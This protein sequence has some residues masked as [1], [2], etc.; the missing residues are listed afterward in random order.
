MVTIEK[1]LILIVDDTPQNIQVLGNI[2]YEKGYNI[3]IST[4]G[5]HALQSVN[6][7]TPDLILLDIQ[8]PEMN[9]FEV[10][11]LLKLDEK[12]KDIP[13]IFLTAIS[14][15]ENIVRGFE[16]GAVDY[17]TKP[18]NT[19]ELIS[20]VGT[21]IELK[22]SREK[23]VELNATKDKFFSIIAH[24]LKNPAFAL[25]F[26]LQ[27]IILQFPG[28]SKEELLESLI[29]L[30][31]ASINLYN[32]LENL[33]LWSKSQRGTL[34]FNP[35]KIPL[36]YLVEKIISHSK[37]SAEN[38][39]IQIETSIE[40][41]LYVFADQMML[42]TVILNLLSNA[43][44]FTH[45]NGIISVAARSDE[46]HVEISIKDS[47]VGINE[48][49]LTNLFSIATTQTTKGTKNEEGSGLGLII[50]KEFIECNHG[51]ISV[52]SRQGEG[53]TFSFKLPK[54]MDN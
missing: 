12:T 19:A 25:K 11:E 35:E 43:I 24:D 2:L 31:D 33:L 16:Y 50:C 45:E 5:E 36:Q 34:G 13:V 49:R 1:A 54:T 38:K 8:M 18:F 27:Q 30:P 9:G 29:N 23:L 53:S 51:E 52:K 44:K 20:R 42:Q 6:V 7:K 46:T 39:N 32:L 21:H 37:A 17:I 28:L 41:S 15:P 26:L 40:D 14:D 3:S 48:T 22:K 4:S 10:C 47:G